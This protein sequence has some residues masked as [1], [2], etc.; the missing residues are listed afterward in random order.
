MLLKGFEISETRVFIDGCILIKFA[1]LCFC[2]ANYAGVRNELNL[3]LNSLS[4]ILH[5]FVW[6]GDI[7]WVGWA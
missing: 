6:L 5:L 1:S 3:Y 4:R 2:V 7:L